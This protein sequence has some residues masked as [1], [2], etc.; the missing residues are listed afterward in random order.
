MGY[1]AV[2]GAGT[3]ILVVTWLFLVWLLRLIISTHWVDVCDMFG[4]RLHW[5]NASLY[6]T[7]IQPAV[8]Q[9]RPLLGRQK[10]DVPNKDIKMP[11]IS[12]G[13]SADLR[14]SF[15]FMFI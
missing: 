11:I 15:L 3:A 12:S 1:I 6:S 8:I 10:A 5:D 13:F 9:T 14:V 4:W 2:N 7:P